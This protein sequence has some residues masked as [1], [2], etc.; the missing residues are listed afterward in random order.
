M[1]RLKWN[2]RAWAWSLERYREGHRMDQG[3][4]IEVLT[5]RRVVDVIRVGYV[6]MVHG[7]VEGWL[8][9]VAP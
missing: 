9:V 2:G 7:S 8:G 1:A 3:R 6:P 5:P 4:R